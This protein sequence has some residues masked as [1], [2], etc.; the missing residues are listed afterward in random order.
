MQI[1]GGFEKSAYVARDICSFCGDSSTFLK[2]L[3]IFWR[4]VGDF[5]E[6][7]GDLRK[8]N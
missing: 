1:L 5:L 6:I 7:L 4:F 8:M 2:I 3:E